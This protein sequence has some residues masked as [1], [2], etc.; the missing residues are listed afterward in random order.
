VAGNAKRERSAKKSVD[1]QRARDRIGF[2]LGLG[3][4]LGLLDCTET[5]FGM[6]LQ[7][8]SHASAI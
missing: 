6:D 1:N 5:N 7:N 2:G 8:S 3:L 4:G